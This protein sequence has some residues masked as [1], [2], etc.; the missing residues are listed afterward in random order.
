VGIYA[1]LDDV[2]L[3]YAVAAMTA[4]QK[5]SMHQNLDLRGGGHSLALDYLFLTG[6]GKVEVRLAGRTLATIEAPRRIADEFKKVEIPIDTR[7]FPRRPRSLPLEIVLHG[8]GVESGVLLDN[9]RFPG[10]ENGDFAT[11]D[12]S[13]WKSRVSPRHGAGSWKSHV[14]HRQGAVG[15]TLA[16]NAQI[17]GDR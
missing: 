3:A 16:P 15:V 9:I 13:G 2:N 12:L 6:T 11:G 7:R 4:T 17:I 5:T 1:A 14:V 8:N 10:L